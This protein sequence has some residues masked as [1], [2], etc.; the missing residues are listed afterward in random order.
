MLNIDRDSG[1]FILR[2]S[3]QLVVSQWSGFIVLN[4]IGLITNSIINS[5]DHGKIR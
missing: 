3:F 4:V 1:L 2:F 5:M